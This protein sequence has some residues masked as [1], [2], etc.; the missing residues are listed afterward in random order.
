VKLN[1]PKCAAKARIDDSKIP[2]NGIYARC[3]RC[4]ER[5]FLRK[6]QTDEASTTLN[7]VEDLP[8][9][10]TDFQASG[11]PA[12]KTEPF[13]SPPLEETCSLCKNRFPQTDMIRMG[14]TWV[15]AQCKPSYLQMLQ[16]GLNEP[17]EMRYAGFWIRFAA[18]FVDGLVVA[19]LGYGLSFIL[20][21]PFAMAATRPET[22]GIL[23]AAGLQFLAQIIIPA[24]YSTFLI[25]KYRA[26]LGKMACGL[27][28]VTSDNE[29]V[30][31]PRAV[32]R[33]FSEM[34]SSI[35]LSI[36]YIMAAFDKEKRAL[37]DRICDTR[38]IY[39]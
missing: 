13:E 2:E 30:S 16:Q 33:H 17:G 11:G 6:D 4:N 7:A 10:G 37:H 29:N 26:T 18:K 23:A 34:L 27:V 1:C 15:C 24:A 14:D 25:G 12:P 38:V 32:G 8:D 39:K 19:V 35:T 21:L 28:V 5:F 9:L 36:G 22:T 20:T 31:Y 3:P